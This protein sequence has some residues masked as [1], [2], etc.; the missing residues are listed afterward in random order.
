MLISERLNMDADHVLKQWEIYINNGDL[1]NIVKL[2]A[3]NAM[4]WGTFST[5]LRDNPELIRDYFQKLFQ[6]KNFKVNFSSAKNR[7]H[8]GV[9]IYSGT[10][11]FSYVDIELISLPARYTFVIC[12]LDSGDYKIVEHHSSLIPT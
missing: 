3:N 2:Y 6:R 10:Y 12:K 7:V 1:P 9:S 8:S 5:I 4:L 11:D